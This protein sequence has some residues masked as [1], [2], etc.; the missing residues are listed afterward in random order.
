[1]GRTHVIG[2]ITFQRQFGFMEKREDVQDMI[3][4][5]GA[6][7]N[8]AGII[9]QVPSLHGLLEISGCRKF[10]SATLLQGR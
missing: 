4:G 1:M 2:A 7:L 3:V 10:G 8:Y 6:G 9:S 5:L